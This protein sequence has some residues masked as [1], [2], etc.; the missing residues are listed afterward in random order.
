[1]TTCTFSFLLI[2]VQIHSGA[3]TPQFVSVSARPDY[4]DSF[5]H[6]ALNR[7]TQLCFQ[8]GDAT[9]EGS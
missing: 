9:P 5:R 3:N 8:P 2:H 6:A 7:A 1:M 4:Q